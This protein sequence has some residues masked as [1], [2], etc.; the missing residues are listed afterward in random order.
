MHQ[1]LHPSRLVPAGFVIENAVH[2]GNR[3]VIT[4]RH[5][6]ASGI[7]PSCGAVSR[8]VHSHYR[9]RVDDLPISGHNVQLLVIARRF[10]CD[11]VLCGRQI[12]AERFADGV[13]A[14]S[15][16]RMASSIISDWLYEQRRAKQ[17]A[18]ASLMA[19]MHG[20]S[21]ARTQRRSRLARPAGQPTGP[22]GQLR[23]PK[24][25]LLPG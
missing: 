12:F 7:C 19:K 21:P 25:M 14:P 6:S 15:A 4:V 5:S 24:S 13:L 11:A 16:R 3:T 10:R 23:A 2:E 20:S 17:L 1:A 9:R 22:F 8:R 18:S